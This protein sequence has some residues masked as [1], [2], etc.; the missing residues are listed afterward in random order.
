M[1]RVKDAAKGIQERL[2][3][4]DPKIQ[5]LALFLLDL[6]M[7]KCTFAFHNQVGLKPFMN[8]LVT[9]ISTESVD[10]NVSYQLLSQVKKKILQLI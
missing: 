7:K 4:V 3:I 9:L 8:T 5:M 2:V 10:Q 6:C 1:A